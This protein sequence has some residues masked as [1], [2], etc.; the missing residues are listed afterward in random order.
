[1]EPSQLIDEAPP[2]QAR[3][4]LHSCCG[5]TRWVERMLALRPFGTTGSMLSAARREWLT[6]GPEHWIEAFSHHPK[7]GDRESVRARFPTTHALS[8]REQA[9]ISSASDRTRE[10]LARG[11]AAYEQRFGY[12]FIICATGKSPDEMLHHL[13]ARL[14]NDPATEVRIAAQEQAQITAL[15]LKRLNQ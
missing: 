5:S 1:M 4:L 6:L 11:N 15:R 9:G 3:A 7:I 12:I 14:Q 13:T 10:A 8:E 2:E